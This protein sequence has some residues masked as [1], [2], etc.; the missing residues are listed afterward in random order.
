MYKCHCG[1]G[2]SEYKHRGTYSNR[3]ILALRIIC[4]SVDFELQLAL[5]V[6]VVVVIRNSNAIIDM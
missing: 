3:T 5:T 2:T 6:D 1:T 4:C